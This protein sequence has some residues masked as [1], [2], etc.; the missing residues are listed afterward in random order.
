MS[1]QHSYVI[2]GNGIAGVT[3]AEI[4][5][6]QDQASSITM[7]ADD[8]FPAYYRPALKDFLGGRLPEEK[9][10]ARPATFYKEQRIRFLSARVMSIN[11]TQHLLLLHNGATVHYDTLLLANGARSRTIECSGLNLAGVSTLRT[12]AD[13]QEILHRLENVQRIVVCGSGTL[14]LESAETLRHRGYQVTHLLRGKTF[15]SEVLDP[16][17]SDM[18][19][20][21]EQR[22]GL[23]VRCEQEI[24]VIV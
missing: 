21:E 16:V 19:L 5:R 2:I 17:A 11:P 9:L 1:R 8:P 10:W 12:V 3:A 20:Q 13:Y 15:W 7:I 18:V 23:E 4:L 24:A 14:A 6:E 22:D